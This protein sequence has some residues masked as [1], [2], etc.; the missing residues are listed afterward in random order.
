MFKFLII[1]YAKLLYE[2]GFGFV[3]E[4]N[5]VGIAHLVFIRQYEQRL[6]DTFKQKCRSEIANSNRCTL[7][8]N[9][10]RKFTMTHYLNK[11][12][13]TR[14]VLTK[15]RL[16]SHR[17]LIEC[18]RGFKPHQHSDIHVVSCLVFM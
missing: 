8:N 2:Y 1:I 10:H 18:G 11:V 12:R 7:Y 3:W 15:L 5:A 17:L 16:I 13:T 9:V 14:R 4:A 6:K